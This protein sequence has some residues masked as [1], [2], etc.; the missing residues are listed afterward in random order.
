M[1]H[2]KF[3]TIGKTV[4]KGRIE[5]GEI[6]LSYPDSGETGGIGSFVDKKAYDR[7][8]EGT[9]QEEFRT[10]QAGGTASGERVVFHIG[11]T[12]L[13]LLLAQPGTEG[14]RLTKITYE[15]KESFI[16]ESLSSE[17]VFVDAQKRKFN[18]RLQAKDNAEPTVV[19]DIYGFTTGDLYREIK[20]KNGNEKDFTFQD[21]TALF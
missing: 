5:D 18:K 9:Y 2:K 19:E 1:A 21:F 7:Y 16:V 13:L 6:E 12:A 8:M 4:I 20:Q 17:V 3:R 15:G 10:L 11:K 14:I